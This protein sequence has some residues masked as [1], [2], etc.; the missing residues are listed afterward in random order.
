[1]LTVT[2]LKPLI[3]GLYVERGGRMGLNFHEFMGVHG[4][5]DSPGGRMVVWE[6]LREMFGNTDVVEISDWDILHN[7]TIVQEFS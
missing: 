4:I 6:E 5:P 3:P 7:S 1:V 2:E